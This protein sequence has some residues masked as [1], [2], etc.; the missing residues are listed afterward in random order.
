MKKTIT[1]LAIVLGISLAGMAQ[2]Q[3]GGV[4]Q[5]GPVIEETSNDYNT[6]NG[7]GL[8]LPGSHGE[9]GDQNGPVGSGLLLLAGLGGA[10]L[11]LKKKEDKE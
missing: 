10:Y 11:I 6:R 7:S 9:T 3:G 8:M 4:F 5:R 2:Q 1:T